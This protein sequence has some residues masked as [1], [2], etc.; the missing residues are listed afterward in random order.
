MKHLS[1]IVLCLCLI[2]LHV[3]SGHHSIDADFTPGVIVTINAVTKEFRFIN[4]HPSVTAEEVGGDGDGKEWTLLLDD[5]WE[6]VESGFSRTT[7][8]PGDELVVSGRP[9]RRDPETLYVRTLERTADGFLYEED[10]G[11]DYDD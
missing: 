8:Q 11:E 4:P 5:R 2:P 7:I 3:A 9:S 10:D 1:A 6:M